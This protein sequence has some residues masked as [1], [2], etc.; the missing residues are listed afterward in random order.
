MDSIKLSEYSK[1]IVQNTT[2]I[3]CEIMKLKTEIISEKNQ[4]TEKQQK[5]IY[6]LNQLLET[7][8]QKKRDVL[9]EIFVYTP[10]KTTYTEQ[11]ETFQNSENESSNQENDTESDSK[12]DSDS[13]LDSESEYEFSDVDEDEDIIVNKCLAK[14]GNKL[15]RNRQTKQYIYITTT[16]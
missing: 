3:V 14:A 2:K 13:D 7:F 9:N 12:S 5:Q 1:Q 11:N 15:R 4:N 10:V 6:I 16:Y 8:C